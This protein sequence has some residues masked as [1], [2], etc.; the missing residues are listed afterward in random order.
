M[1][2]PATN[3][4]GWNE[5]GTVAG[6]GRAFIA[7]LV[8]P[9]KRCGCTRDHCTRQATAEDLRCDQCRETCR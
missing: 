8:D 1:T 7:P 9:R 4:H 2:P 5:I 3:D 6:G